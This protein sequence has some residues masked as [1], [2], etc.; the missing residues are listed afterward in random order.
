MSLVFFA[1]VAA[2]ACF[3]LEAYFTNWTVT[4][5]GG[6][7]VLVADEQ[8]PRSLPLPSDAL[9]LGTAL[10]PEL[11]LVK[12]FSV[13]VL[14]TTSPSIG[15]FMRV[16]LDTPVS[17]DQPR[18]LLTFSGSSVSVT[19]AVKRQSPNPNQME[20][21]FT[22]QGV[23]LATI[24]CGQVFDTITDQ[25]VHFRFRRSG[26]VE[27]HINGRSPVSTTFSNFTSVQIV[28]I[29]GDQG[30]TN[31]MAIDNLAVFALGDTENI[32]MQIQE[33]TNGN[34]PQTPPTTAPPVV[35]PSP[36]PRPTPRPSPA[37]T[38]TPTPAP[39]PRPSPAPTPSPT[40]K[41]TPAPTPLPTPRPTRAPT[42]QPTPSPTP[43]ALSACSA[44][45]VCAQCVDMSFH[46]ER[47][48]RFCAGACR[49]MSDACDGVASGGVCPTPA[50]TLAPTT[51]P[52]LTELSTTASFDPLPDTSATS[53]APTETPTSIVSAS[54]VSS[55][56]SEDVSNGAESSPDDSA[57][58]IGAVVGS[59]AFL[60]LVATIVGIVLFLRKKKKKNVASSPAPAG[61]MEM[62]GREKK[63]DYGNLPKASN[64]YD[65]G[66]VKQVEPSNYDKGDVHM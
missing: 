33:L 42:P 57:T 21:I 54:T 22:L 40:P 11:K 34:K 32:N 1:F 15:V 3:D 24:D 8:T 20:C 64:E 37:P 58:I 28:S 43:D 13:P 36:T 6:G 52:T 2:A 17:G 23:L 59:V 12:A 56:S 38:P 62:K 60:C 50:P 47:A 4:S 63:S 30:N 46:P 18:T 16:K 14:R 25:R 9:R 5:G 53:S 44:F 35:T 7:A 27:V 39:T 51:G 55:G 48:C 31:A 66:V 45:G 65:V 19:V 41:L 10:D 29:A 49:D 26:S 61:E